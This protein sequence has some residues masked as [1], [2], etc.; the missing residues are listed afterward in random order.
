MKIAQ[1]SVLYNRA[2]LAIISHSHTAKGLFS[3]L[4]VTRQDIMTLYMLYGDFVVFK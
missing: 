3:D 1:L 4:G 2:R